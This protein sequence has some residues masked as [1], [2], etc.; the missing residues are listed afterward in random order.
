MKNQSKAQRGFTLIEL[1][2]VVLVIGVLAA[3]A[4][5]A[6][7]QHVVKSRRAAAKACVEEAA[8][9]MERHY[10]TRLSYLDPA[11]NAAPALPAMQC[12]TDLAMFYDVRV[13]AA[14]ARTYTLQ[15]VPTT[16]Q[17]DAKC[18]TLTTTE[19]GVKGASGSDGA[20]LCW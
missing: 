14:A 15:A 1:M 3:I 9:F 4:Y 11:T 17:K 10:T 19:A 18:G 2:I 16:K 7:S 6:Y 5:P 13:Q 12:R 20:A 8:Q